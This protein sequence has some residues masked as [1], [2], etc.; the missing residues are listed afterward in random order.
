ML[1][2]LCGVADVMNPGGNLT[3]TRVS[4]VGFQ[5]GLPNGFVVKYN[6]TPDRKERNHQYKNIRLHQVSQAFSKS[7]YQ[8]INFLISSPNICCGYSKEPSQ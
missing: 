5:S 2:G 6:L 3:W 1:L 7:T 4:I 8:K